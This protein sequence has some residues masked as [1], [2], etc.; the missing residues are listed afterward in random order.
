MIEL[1]SKVKDVITGLEGAATV[2]AQYITG[3]DRYNINPQVLKDGKPIEGTYLDEGR[4]E[5]V[6]APPSNFPTERRD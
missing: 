2:R 3:E 4:L 1:G 6:S 5:V